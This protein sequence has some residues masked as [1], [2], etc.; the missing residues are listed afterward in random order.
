MR[1]GPVA[2]ACG[3]AFLTAACTLCIQILVHR[4]ISAK[5]LNNFAFLVISLTMLGFALSGVLLTRLLPRFLSRLPDAVTTCAALLVLTLLGATILFYDADIF[6]AARNRPHFVVLFL[7]TIPYALVFAVPFTFC[8]LI[9]GALLSSPELPTRRVYFY[10]LLGSAVGAFAVIQVIS[11]LGVENGLLL[12]CAVMLTGA[13]LLAP[14]H[15]PVA[16][17]LAAAAAVAIASCVAFEDRAFVMRYPKGTVLDGITANARGEYG[18]ETVVWDP[19]ARI[20]VSRIRPVDPERMFY[21]SLVGTNQ[22]FHAR[23]KR[24]LTQNNNAWTYAVEYD[25]TRESLTGIEETIYAAAYQA[26]SVRAPRVGV[27]GVGGGFDILNA[28]YFGASRV[29]AVEVN[30]ATVSL[31][32]NRYRDYFRHWVDDPRVNLVLGEGRHYLWSTDETY[33]VLQLS[34]V[35]SFAGTAAAAHVFSEN[36]LYTAEAF[37]LYLSRLTDQGILNMMR[38]EYWPPREMLRALVTAVEALRRA[39][40]A[41]PADHILMLTDT[42]SP[43]FTALLVKKTPFTAEERGR[44]VE[45]AD[46]SAQFEVSAAPG[47]SPEAT[48]YQL[49]LSL[50]DPKRERAFVAGYPWNVAPAGD[51]RPFFF[52]YSFWWHLFPADSTVWANTPV[53]EYSILILGGVVALATLACIYVPLRLLAG[54]AATTPARKR[55]GVYFAGAGV[56][57]MAVEI[58]LLQKFGL[59]LGHPNYSLSVVLAALLLTSG[60]G[61]LFS[62]RI[63]STLR[64]IRFVSYVLAGLI[65]AEYAL[66]FPRLSGLIGLPFAA[67]VLIVFALVAP[68]GVCLGTFVP[69]ALDRLKPEAPS[70]VPWAWGLNGIFSVLSPV[71]SIAFSMT[72]GI[73]ALLLGSIPVYLV[74]GF[75]LPSLAEGAEAVALSRRAATK[76][77]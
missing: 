37:D 25:G 12:S 29:T 59:F 13:V 68:L 71:L 14:P 16:R 45:W 52:N 22:A 75:A 17:S 28:L 31:L 47:M 76:P 51:D 73:N 10:D 21:R 23:F 74:T 64:E 56:G 70:Y 42:P 20:E 26:A 65:L 66:I 15:G 19:V 7:K 27:V 5:L 34:G 50:D 11:A 60:L 33:D 43:V 39:G 67:R 61:S 72:S 57:Y 69:T 32:R 48:T 8:G 35:D 62:A 54:R 63:L 30:A 3:L 36:Y 40:V 44:I 4:A 1:L 6:Q 38:L 53:M 55:Y 24:M 49:F 18:I 46:R 9:L 2:R 41:H 58:A 77:A